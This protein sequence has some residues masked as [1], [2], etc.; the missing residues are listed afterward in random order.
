MKVFVKELR[1]TSR[2][3]VEVIDITSDVENAV[4]ES[5]VKNGI[6]LVFAPHATAAI[7]LNEDE[8]GLL[9]DIEDKILE[10]FPRRG[11][12][13]HNLIDDNANSHLASAFLGQGKVI[14]LVNGSLIR[15]TWQNILLV[16]LDGPR[17]SR[18]VMVEVIGE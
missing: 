4:N 6:V 3:Q 11:N 15:G 16:E 7:I 1:Y 5:G 13:R 14:P 17:A 18:R 2:R 10:L 8:S 9:K 12:Y